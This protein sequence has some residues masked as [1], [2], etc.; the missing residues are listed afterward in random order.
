MEQGGGGGKEG[1][2][3]LPHRRSRAGDRV[4]NA[5]LSLSGQTQQTR[6]EQSPSPAKQQS[7]D[8]Y[9]SEEI[10]TY[11]DYEDDFEAELPDDVEV[12]SALFSLHFPS[13]G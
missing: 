4:R 7:D 10:D 6:S 3:V 1:S 9:I 5:K 11:E 13:N 2:N 12:V 8:S